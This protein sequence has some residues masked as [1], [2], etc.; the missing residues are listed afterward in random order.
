MYKLSRLLKINGHN[1]YDKSSNQRRSTDM[2]KMNMK[3]KRVMLISTFLVIGIALVGAIYIKTNTKNMNEDI[4]IKEKESDDTVVDNI[5]EPEKGEEK[6]EVPEIREEEV[7]K[8]I[9]NKVE[10]E[11]IEEPLPKEPEKPKSTPPEKK[12]QTKDGVEDMTKE[13]EYDEEE[14]IYIPEEKEEPQTEKDPAPKDNEEDNLVP[15]S[16]NPFLQDNIPNNGDGGEMKGE[17]LGDGEW[18]TGDKF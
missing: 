1:I 2:K 17:D 6:I 11:V 8:D 7:I 4:L 13:P 15:E 16:E 9:D 5:E 3:T 18:G 10:K 12:P 14:V